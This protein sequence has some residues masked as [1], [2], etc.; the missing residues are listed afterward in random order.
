MAPRSQKIANLPHGTEEMPR[1]QMTRHRTIVAAI[2]VLSAIGFLYFVL[3]KLAGLRQTWD[4]IGH[5]SPGWLIVAAVFEALSFGGYIVLFRTVFVRGGRSR[6]DWPTSY[7]ITMAGL[8]ATRLFATAGAG[9]VALTVW[10]LRR[11]GM[12]RRVVAAQMVAFMALLYG[13]F[14]F[15][16]VIFGVG[17]ASG[18]FPGGGTF[19][20]T[21]VPAIFGAVVIGGALAFTLVPDDF[22]RRIEVAQRRGG[23][24]GALLAR[25]A[26]VP[27]LTASG[28]RGAVAIVR[29][30]DPLSAGAIAWWGFDIATLWASFQAFGAAPPFTV[31]TMAYFL[32]MF[33][34][35]LPLPGGIG[36]VDGGMI[37]AFLAFGVA[38]PLAVV[39]VLVYRG[40]AFW[41]PTIPGAVAY[42][43]LRRRVQDWT[44]ETGSGELDGASAAP[45]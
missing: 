35:L 21:I 39:A 28:V 30:R 34:N 7:E 22:A 32:G 42:V 3:P 25:L 15:A 17:L 11:S 24:T 20:L 40:F 19:P 18:L 14:M 5:G 33:G 4:R 23:R 6:I 43:Q 16:L 41:L 1:V 37:G 44:E 38:G 2:F 13:V 31:I 36:G 27:A 10:A 12:N 9:G 26:T 45:A 29:S 8:A